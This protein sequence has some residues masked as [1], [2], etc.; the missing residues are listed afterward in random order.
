M[1]LERVLNQVKVFD[2]SR[3]LFEFDNGDKFWVVAKSQEEATKCLVEDYNE[4]NVEEMDV[5]EIPRTEHFEI[6]DDEYS[7][8]DI[9]D[10]IDIDA[11][12][13]CVEVPYMV[14]STIC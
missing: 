7:K 3:K 12:D 1:S 13:E 4:E 8:I 14:A 2:P 11:A 9:W 10:M 5:I 6:R